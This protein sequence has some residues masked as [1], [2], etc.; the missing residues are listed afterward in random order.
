MKIRYDDEANE[1]L[2]EVRECNGAEIH[3]DEW[4]IA[5]ALASHGK[6]FLGSPRGPGGNWKRAGLTAE[7]SRT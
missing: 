4:P 2:R 5:E 3:R 6:I 7:E 1:M